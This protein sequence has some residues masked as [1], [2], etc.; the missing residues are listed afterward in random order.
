[1]RWTKIIWRSNWNLTVFAPG[2][3]VLLLFCK[4]LLTELFFMKFRS[5][6]RRCSLKNGVLRNFAKFTGKHLRQSLLFNKVAGLRPATLLKKRICHR[7]FPVNF[8]K[9]LRTPFLQ[10]TSE[11]LLL[12]VANE[13]SKFRHNPETC[14]W[15]LWS[16]K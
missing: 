4:I 1:M 16:L 6:H 10:T 12:E 11:R 8:T 13:F 7:C 3:F 14:Q 9:F 15:R 2:F 5:S